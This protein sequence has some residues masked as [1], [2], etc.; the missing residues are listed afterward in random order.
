MMAI[1]YY[2]PIIDNH[3]SITTPDLGVRSQSTTDKS[4]KLGRQEINKNIREFA[5]VGDVKEKGETQKNKRRP[6]NLDAFDCRSYRFVLNKA[7]IS[8]HFLRR[9][10]Q[11]SCLST[12][13]YPKP[14]TPS[15]VCSAEDITNAYIQAWNWGLKALRFI[16]TDRNGPSCSTRKPVRK[17]TEVD[18]Q[19]RSWR[20]SWAICWNRS[21][22]FSGNNYLGKFLCIKYF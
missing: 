7:F 8:K 5:P 11:L 13:R 22:N 21:S 16:E 4:S 17:L 19:V 15:K 6:E 14:H 9:R 3:L 2:S 10:L 1:H 20:N 18:E 12:A